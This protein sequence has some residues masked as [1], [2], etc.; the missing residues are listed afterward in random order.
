M[1]RNQN[2]RQVYVVLLC[3]FVFSF[4]MHAKLSVYSPTSAS[5]IG[6]VHSVSHV[7]KLDLNKAGKLLLP[8]LLVLLLVA[9]GKEDDSPKV[10]RPPAFVRSFPAQGFDPDRF[11]RPPPVIPG[12]A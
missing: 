8:A 6:A 11:L 9:T 2:A 5:P 7:Q 12:L 3:L 4:F 1:F 10:P